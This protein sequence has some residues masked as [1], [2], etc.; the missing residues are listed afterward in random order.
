MD[1]RKAFRLVL[2]GA[3]A[4]SMAAC[5]SRPKP[6][7]AGAGATAGATGPAAPGVGTGAGSGLPNAAPRGAVG[8]TGMA[9]T[10]G[11]VE[12]FTVNVGERVFFDTDQYTVRA[13]A[14][15]VLQA[16]AAWLARYP[17]VRVIIEGNA[18]ERGTREY[19]L[20]LGARRAQAVRDMLVSQGVA[21][22]RIE[23]VSYGKER[24]LDGGSGEEAWARNRN[25]RTAITGG[26][27]MGRVS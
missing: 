5:A 17:Q 2:I 3:V 19:N 10:P 12:D 21:A 20:A 22:N 9:A 27:V 4:A 6:G 7:A 8:A 13:D 25:A 24:P 26:A 16:Q 11:S 14:R 23:T 18:D 1:T 15:P